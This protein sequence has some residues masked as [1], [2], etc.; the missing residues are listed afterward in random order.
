[1]NV[2]A[3]RIVQRG[4]D[5]K[6]VFVCGMHRSGTSRI[7]QRI[8][9]LKDC[10]GFGSTGRGVL[11]DEG[12]YLQDVYPPDT[13]YGGVGR[14]GFAP[15][16]HLTECSPLLTPENV[17]RLRQEWEA[18]WDPSKTI[19]VEKTPG[20]LLKT[21]FLQAAFPNAYFIVIKRHPV[22]VSLA[23]RKWSRTSLHNLFEHWLRCYEILDGDR[24]QLAHLYELSYEDYIKDQR[25]YLDE[26]A[27]FIGTEPSSSVEEDTADTY[28][29]SYFDQWSRM[30][31]RSPLRSYYRAIAR[32]YEESFAKHGYSLITCA[33]QAAP[34][35]EAPGPVRR[36][37]DRGLY[38]GADIYAFLWRAARWFRVRVLHLPDEFRVRVRETFRSPKAQMP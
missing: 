13:A 2:E 1:M 4:N 26:I 6:Y 28:N 18:C 5:M 19:R 37:V 15:Q 24:V 7:A 30:L 20:N 29:K 23:S 14:F 8:G 17:L 22:A 21:R 16:S 32:D 36:L 38:G 34:R 3:A 35:L 27:S 25:K 33:G 31:T 10:A 11:I 12:Q 9:Q